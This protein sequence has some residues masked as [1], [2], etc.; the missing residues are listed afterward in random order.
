MKKTILLLSLFLTTSTALTAQDRYKPSKTEIQNSPS[1][2]QEMYKER[3]NIYLVDRLKK[4]YYREND[5]QKNYHT[6]L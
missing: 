6:Q 3:P 4:Q 2:V 5:F 1:W